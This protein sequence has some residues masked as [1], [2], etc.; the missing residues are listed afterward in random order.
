MTRFPARAKTSE[1]V[2]FGN[3]EIAELAKYYFDLDSPYRPVAFVVDDM[4]LKEVDFEGLPIVPWS[5]V[6]L[7]YPPSI[8]KMHVALSY[9]GLNKLRESKYHQCKT[10]GYELVSYFSSE[11][12]TYPDLVHGE[13]CFVLENQNIQPRVKLGDNVM[14]WSGN[15]IGH[16]STI[17]SHTYVASHVV[18]S[19]HVSV[20]DR[21]FIGVNASLRDFINIGEDCFVGMSSVVTKDLVAGSVVLPARSEIISGADAKAQRLITSTFGNIDS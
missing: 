1:I 8:Y 15:H 16:G 4:Y 18:I 21:C 13:N 12:T 20:G 11:A 7:K 19:G 17:G 5:E 9:R 14:L 10:A 2:I 6:T 3:A